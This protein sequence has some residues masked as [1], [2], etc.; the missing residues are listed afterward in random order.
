MAGRNSDRAFTLIEML[1]VILVV[2]LLI[3]LLLPAVMQ[4]RE[5]ARRAHC[6]NNLYQHGVALHNYHSSFGVLPPG[7]VNA[8]GP[9]ISAA[10]GYHMNWIVQL[11]PMQSQENLFRELDFESGAYSV[12]N[13]ALAGTA[14]ST[15]ICVSDPENMQPGI[16]QNSYAG[17]T[18]G[19]NVPI[20]FDN[21][22]LLF[23][24]SSVRFRE[25]EDGASNTL[26]VGERRRDDFPV[27]DLG[28]MSGT[29]AT[30]RNTGVPI[31]Q[32]VPGR[33]GLRTSVPDRNQQSD[34][35]SAELM[36]PEL[37]TGGFSSNHR[38][39]C[40]F[41]VADGAVRFIGENI[42]SSVLQNLGDRDDG[43]LMDEF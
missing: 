17:C 9:V 24:N 32:A 12:N 25:V 16:Y 1:I 8:T 15:L 3:A 37:R 43:H 36:P 2:S 31:N 40:H 30:L 39:G 21:T 41:L 35:E 22:G 18:G 11:L 6:K 19:Q 33:R 20:D 34:T 23:L 14:I 28:W 38:G 27:T 29:S 5:A 4:S 42:T 10:S 26:L 13:A 7:S